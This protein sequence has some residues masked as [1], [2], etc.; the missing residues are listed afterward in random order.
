MGRG[1]DIG[2]LSFLNVG[3][4]LNHL[5]WQF[6]TR[7]AIYIISDIVWQVVWI[8]YGNIRIGGEPCGFYCLN[9]GI[10]SGI[11]GYDVATNEMLLK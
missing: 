10:G 3:N 8:S 6:A 5:N 2:G 9:G 7:D 1:I 11:I 4:G